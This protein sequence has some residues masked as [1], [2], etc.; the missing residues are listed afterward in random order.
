MKILEVTQG[1]VTRTAGNKVEVDHGDGT[2]TTVD[3]QK[4][5]QAIS[6][7]DK[8]QLRINTTSKNSRM[9][10]GNQRSQAPRAGEKIEIDDE[11]Q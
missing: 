8:G 1:R 7:D 10:R 5:P 3:T 11:D 4:N 2:T 6:R 9:N